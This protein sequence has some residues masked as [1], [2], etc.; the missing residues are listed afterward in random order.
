VRTATDAD[1]IISDIT[2]VALNEYVE[3]KKFIGQVTFELITMS[4]DPTTFDL[5]INYG[6]AKYEDFG[7]HDFNT[8]GIEAVG[9]AGA[10]DANFNITL[11]KHCDADW[12]YS[13]AAFE[14]TPTVIIDLQTVH[15]TEYSTING[16]PFAFKRIPMGVAVEGSASEGVV[17]RIVTGQNNTVQSMDL[18]IGVKFTE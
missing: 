18:H 9:Y 16:H 17:I 4:G 5:D 10:T 14:S 12:N 3:G 15:N 6:F 1:T 2:A 7:N 11:F 8:L 13:A